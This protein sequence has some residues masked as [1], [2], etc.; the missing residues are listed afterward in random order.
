MAMGFARPGPR[1][2]AARDAALPGR[3]LS[4]QGRA[5]ER[6]VCGGFGAHV[7][8]FAG[9]EGH[10][11][12]GLFNNSKNDKG[13]QHNKIET[14]A[15]IVYVSAYIQVYFDVTRVL[16]HAD[17]ILAE[18]ALPESLPCAKAN[19]HVTLCRSEHVAPIFAQTL[20][21]NPSSC[22]AS[23][24]NDLSVEDLELM[25]QALQEMKGMEARD[26][27]T[28]RKMTKGCSTIKLRQPQ[29]SCMFLLIY[30][31]TLM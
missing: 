2:A 25:S 7:P 29:L 16:Q 11:G 8:S 24:L 5:A 17:M 13:L 20:L 4:S 15:A 28:T 30:R 27:S 18:V 26:C 22:V 14:A 31:S 9:D 23:P 19:P 21:E 3:S 12:P 1:G 10:G 6:F